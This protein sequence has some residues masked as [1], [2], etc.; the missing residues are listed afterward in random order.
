MK[1]GFKKLCGG[2]YAK[3]QKTDHHLVECGLGKQNMMIKNASEN[4]KETEDSV[5]FP[6]KKK[7]LGDGGTEC[8]H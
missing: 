5:I 3:L 8:V 4:E 2:S 1:W 7:L 6:G